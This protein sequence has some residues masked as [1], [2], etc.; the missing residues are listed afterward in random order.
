M[1]T[2]NNEIENHLQGAGGH[3][4]LGHSEVHH[5]GVGVV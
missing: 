3:L 4:H 2:V 5:V 1:E